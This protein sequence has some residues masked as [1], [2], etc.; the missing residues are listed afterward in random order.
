MTGEVCI[1]TRMLSVSTIY[2]SLLDALAPAIHA[3]ASMRAIRVISALVCANV[4]GL[5]IAMSVAGM[6]IDHDYQPHKLEILALGLV[7]NVV[8]ASLLQCRRAHWSP[9]SHGVKL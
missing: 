8:A 6:L 4:A 9:R 3:V 7:L 5:L 2:D 1:T